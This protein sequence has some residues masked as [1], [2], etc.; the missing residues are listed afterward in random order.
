MVRE[1]KIR[2]LDGVMISSS[3]TIWSMVNRNR[4]EHELKSIIPKI[5]LNTSYRKEELCMSKYFL[6]RGTMK[7]LWNDPTNYMKLE[8]STEQKHG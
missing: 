1:S 6:K 8:E 3:D 7:L 4:I 2:D 5:V